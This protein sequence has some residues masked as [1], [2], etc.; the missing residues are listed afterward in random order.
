[1]ACLDINLGSIS[2]PFQIKNRASYFESP[3]TPG[4]QGVAGLPAGHRSP[5]DEKYP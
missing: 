5:K 1:L 4:S 2:F 3:N